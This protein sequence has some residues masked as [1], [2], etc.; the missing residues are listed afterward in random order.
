MNFKLKMVIFFCV[1]CFSIQK[2]NAQTVATKNNIALVN[3][4]LFEDQQYGVTKYIALQKNVLAEFKPRENEIVSMQAKIENLKKEIESNAS[5]TT[6]IQKKMDEYD[7]LYRSVTMK[8]ES[9][10]TELQRRYNEMLTPLKDRMVEGIKQWCAQKGYTAMV[11]IAKDEKGMF[12]WM[13]DGAV[14]TT[15]IELIKYLNSVL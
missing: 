14:K 10:K 9:Y 11:D 5:N 15:T 8:T 7:N 2:L 13:D 6:Q 4:Y 12:L 1:V 3:S